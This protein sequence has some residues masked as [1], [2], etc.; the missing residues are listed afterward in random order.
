[1]N[2][3]DD[4]ESNRLLKDLATIQS[5]KRGWDGEDAS[6]LSP[7]AA[8]NVL[9][10]L[11][12]CSKVDLNGWNLFSE[13]NGTLIMENEEK[14]AQI[15]IANNELSYFKE[16]DGTLNGANHVKISAETLLDIIRQINQ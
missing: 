15:N 8:E 3:N 2:L 14:K 7:K 12:I 10:L 13:K 6:R 11:R 4:N 16:C 9:Q 1:M 5:Y